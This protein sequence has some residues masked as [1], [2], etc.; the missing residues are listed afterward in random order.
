MFADNAWYTV[1]LFSFIVWDCV[2]INT[3]SNLFFA[4]DVCKSAQNVL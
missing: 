2:L 1:N 3:Q 4:D